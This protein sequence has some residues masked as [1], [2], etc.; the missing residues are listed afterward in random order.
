MKPFTSHTLAALPSSFPRLLAWAGL[1]LIFTVGPLL[2]AINTASFT[3]TLPVPAGQVTPSW[4]GHPDSPQANFATLNLPILTPEPN[5]SL[6][7]TVFFQEKDGGFLRIKW[8][9]TQGAQTLSENF[10]EGIG[11]SNQRSLLISPDTLLGDGTLS[12]QCG[13]ESLGIAKIKLEW[14]ENKNGIVSP[15]IQD[16]LVTPETGTTQSARNLTGQLR[17]PDPA[18]WHDQL[19][20]LPITDQPQ[21]IEQGVEFSVQLDQLPVAGRLAL[22]EAGLPLGQHLVVW[23]NQQRAGTITP[24]VPELTDGGYLS[25]PDSTDSYVGWRNGS[26]YVPVS[27]LKV[28]VNTVQ[29]AP[30]SDIAPTSDT[31][32]PAVPLAIKEVV[33]QL[34]Y[35]APTPASNVST[36]PTPTPTPDDSLPQQ[37]DSTPTG[38][39]TST[40]DE[41]TTSPTPTPD[42]STPGDTARSLELRAP[43]PTLSPEPPAPTPTPEPVA[44]S[45]TS[46]TPTENINILP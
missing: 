29:F 1:L 45:S 7:V 34:N 40:P 3:L 12:F 43:L 42:L 23:I 15:Q 41:T 36:A 4:L 2:G 20:A 35:P 44:P 33:L 21:R 13:D 46:S 28:G 22:R 8:Q 11:M 9:G 10:Y 24:A 5:A 17:P 6:L 38:P 18:E 27:F 16:L 30:E 25:A 37:T 14:L 19:V 31:P 39:V 32:P 26:F